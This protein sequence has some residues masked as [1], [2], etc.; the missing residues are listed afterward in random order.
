MVRRTLH[1][2][3]GWQLGRLKGRWVATRRD[4]QGIRA[5]YRLALPPAAGLTEAKQALERL[6]R[7]VAIKPASPY[8]ESLMAAYITDRKLDG[9]STVKQQASWLALA[10][11]FGRM[12]P[13]DIDKA[14]CRR[15]HDERIASGRKPGTVI[16]DLGV[17]RAALGWARK[18]KLITLADLPHVW[19]PSQPA[20]REVWLDRDD[21]ARLIE[22]ASMPH[23]RLYI[24]LAVTTAARMEALLT[25]TWDRVDLE[26]G[27]IDLRDPERADT[28]KGRAIVP[29]NAT[30]R[31]ALSAAKAGS[32][33]NFVIEWNGLPV[34]S[35]KTGF[36]AAKRRANLPHV[37]PHDLRRS[38]GR[39]MV[40]A[41]VEMAEVSQFLGHRSIAMTEKVYARFS[42]DYLRRA[43][44]AL[45]LGVQR[46][47]I[48]SLKPRKTP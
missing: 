44:G 20:P 30:A 36:A 16:A 18:Q 4:E 42:P 39:I 6:A 2:A 15:F 35:I 19:M 7:D 48:H 17:L 34:E 1:T 40:E 33:S 21:I 32:I 9:K 45:E 31:A 37:T 24:V 29:I 46:T 11:I 27:I 38:A 22:A 5:R 26:G 41:S 14:L 12:R 10:P 28:A 23:I 43:A 47:A 13:S 8:I 25:L 3:G